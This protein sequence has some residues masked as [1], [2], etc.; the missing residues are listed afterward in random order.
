[1]YSMHM[2]IALCKNPYVE[3]ELVGRKFRDHIDPGLVRARVQL[4]I[5]YVLNVA[6]GLRAT[7][8]LRIQYRGEQIF[9][10]PL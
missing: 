9:V 1:M 6:G 7:R 2:E 4:Y 8:G 5:Q 10:Y 3:N